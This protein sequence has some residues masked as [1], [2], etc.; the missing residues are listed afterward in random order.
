MGKWC[1][2]F[3][4]EVE[5]LW[6]SIIKIKYGAEEGGWFTKVVRGSFGVGL[7]KE[8]YKESFSIKQ[9][10]NLILGDGS[11][12][13]FWENVWCSEEPFSMLFPM[14]YTMSG[15]KRAS[16]KEVWRPVGELGGWDLQFE[17]HFND[18]E[19]ETVENLFNLAIS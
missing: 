13:K 6:K 7:W 19:L 12:I 14:L 18:W 3:G 4:A 10:N 15:S 16:V 9:H 17:R 11:I 1:W 8:I 5:G 2:R